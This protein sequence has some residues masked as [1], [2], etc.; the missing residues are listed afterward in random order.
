MSRTGKGRHAS[1]IM[2][3][4]NMKYRVTAGA[5]LVALTTAAVFVLVGGAGGS[6]EPSSG[7][8]GAPTDVGFVAPPSPADE[9]PA[10]AIRAEPGSDSSSA[11]DLVLTAPASVQPGQSV[12]FGGRWH[13]PDGDRVNGEVDLQRIEGNS[14]ATLTTMR[15]DDG[16]GE[17]DVQI[18]GSGI[19]RLAYGGS[20]EL[21]AV[22]SGEMVVRAG[23]PLKSRITA[24]AENTGDGAVSVTAAWTTEGGVPIVGDLGLQQAVDEEWKHVSKAVTDGDGTAVAKAEAEHTARFRFAYDGG[25]RFGVVASD[26]AVALGDDVRTIPVEI[27]DDAADID[28]L[29]NGVGC[30]YTPVSSGTFVAAHDYLGNAWWNSIPVDSYVELTGELAGLYE[31][32]DRVIAPGRGSAL[33]PASDW[34]CGDACDV[35]LQTC[36]G[37][38]TGFTWLREVEDVPGP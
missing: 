25:S 37:K 8:S 20:D 9:A 22:A 31:V 5:G 26:G 11:G 14:W 6:D 29:P 17:V 1:L 7:V 23:E 28:V 2:E 12:T 19:Y 36:Q 38:N 24:T 10:A 30:H 18:N 35:I 34:T 21:D 33:G 15:V 16:F 3:D 4:R 32:V 27:C 13:T